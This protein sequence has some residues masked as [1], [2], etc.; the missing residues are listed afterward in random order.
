MLGRAGAKNLVD[1]FGQ[2]VA[3][4]VGGE[5]CRIILKKKVGNLRGT[6]GRH[7]TSN[8]KQCH[9]ISSYAYALFSG[10]GSRKRFK[11]V[12]SHAKERLWWHIKWLKKTSRCCG[13]LLLAL[14]GVTGDTGQKKTKKPP[15]SSVG[16]GGCQVTSHGSVVQ[17]IKDRRR[18]RKNFIDGKNRSSSSQVR[19]ALIQEPL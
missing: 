7:C 15:Y 4:S 16:A 10:C 1:N 2:E 14:A 6:T 9:I 3:A 18:R 8:R 19:G 5:C 13:R 12:H 17:L 11:E